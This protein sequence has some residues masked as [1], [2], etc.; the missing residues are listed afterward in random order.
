MRQHLNAY[1]STLETSAIRSRRLTSR[2]R[3]YFSP[4]FR[5]S[6]LVGIAE[7]SL[8][9]CDLDHEKRIELHHLLS[10]DYGD[11]ATWI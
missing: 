11:E 7:Q 6:L 10:F 1:F 5:G 4:L 8:R 9:F 3:R 2:R